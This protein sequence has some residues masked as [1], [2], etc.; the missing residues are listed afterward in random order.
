MNMRLL[1]ITA[2]V[3]LASGAALACDDLRVTGD[4]DGGVPQASMVPEKTAA[5]P[6]KPLVVQSKA[7]PVAKQK[8]QG[9]SVPQGVALART[10][11]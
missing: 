6:E 11:N 1:A 8:A 7:R 10:S 9:K 5:A 3:V 4:Y 2:S